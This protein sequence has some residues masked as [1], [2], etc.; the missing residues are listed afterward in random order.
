MCCFYRCTKRGVICNSAIENQNSILINTPLNLALCRTPPFG[1]IF[2][3]TLDSL[4]G[5]L[6]LSQRPENI[7]WH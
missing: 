5:S 3:R 7:S 2:M 1:G 6:G 4:E